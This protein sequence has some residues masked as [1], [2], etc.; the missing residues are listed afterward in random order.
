MLQDHRDIQE[1]TKKKYRRVPHPFAP[2][3]K[4]WERCC[5]KRTF[6]VGASPSFRTY[7]PTL[8]AQI[9]T[10]WVSRWPSFN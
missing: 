5:L 1:W 10:G 3:A 7:A 2:F 8:V 9:A 6:F 4:G